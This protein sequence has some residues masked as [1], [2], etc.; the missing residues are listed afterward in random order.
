MLR[1]PRSI[2]VPPMGRM[3]AFVDGENLVARYQ[4]ML[5]NGRTRCDGVQ[6]C[7][8][9]YV[10]VSHPGL[11]PIVP[12]WNYMIRATYYTYATG[13]NDFIHKVSEKIASLRPLAS[14][15]LSITVLDNRFYPCVFKKPK[16]RK[17]QRGRYT[18]DDRHTFEYL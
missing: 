4:D 6:H 17:R 13:D 5:K 16:M 2:A 10:W 18:N 8:D 15:E 9:T 3:M 11:S 12:G 7:V 1:D 14:L